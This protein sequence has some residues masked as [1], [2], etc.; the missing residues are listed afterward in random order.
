MDTTISVLYVSVLL[1]RKSKSIS[2]SIYMLKNE[3]DFLGSK[4]YY[5]CP[6]CVWLVH[7]E[8]WMLEPILVLDNQCLTHTYYAN[9]CSL[10]VW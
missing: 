9:K 8:C 1:K 5:F 7:G 2:L 6:T 3:S 4:I 10:C